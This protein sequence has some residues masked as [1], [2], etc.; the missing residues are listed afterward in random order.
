MLFLRAVSSRAL[1]WLQLPSGGAI[2]TATKPEN[3]SGPRRPRPPRWVTALFL[4]VTLGLLLLPQGREAVSTVEA[5]W[6]D[7]QLTASDRHRIEELA[8]R[9]EKAKDAKG[10]AFAAL[11]N[12]DGEEA[13]QFADRAVAMD[14]KLVW[15]YASRFQRPVETPVSKERI[16]RLLGS[17]PE[18]AFGYLYAAWAEAEP[19]LQAALRD[20][21]LKNDDLESNLAGDAKWVELMGSAFRAP[22]YDTYYDR[23][24]ELS[25]EVWSRERGLG[26]APVAYSLWSHSIPS[27]QEVLAYADLRIR[28]ANEESAANH[29]ERA[30]QILRG[31]RS[32][33]ER[34]T[35][36]SVSE[37]ERMTGLEVER[38][39]TE[40]LQKFYAGKGGEREAREAAAELDRIGVQKTQILHSFPPIYAAAVEPYRRRA[41]LV[42][43]A[44][45]LGIIS[46]LASLFCVLLLE[47]HV[48]LPQ[49]GAGMARRALYLSADY[50]PMLFL[51]SSVA[52]LLSFRP[53]AA[54]L[55]EFRTTDLP[56]IDAR[57]VAG[58][59]FVLGTVD[60]MGALHDAYVR[61]LVLTVVLA[62][63][64]VV[65]LV[66]GIRRNKRAA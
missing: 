18:N 29:P 37:I 17:D 27:I 52:L 54:F 32:F 55:A 11:S 56:S 10:I 25:R 65:V 33:G 34:M 3:S 13:V 24:R 43:Y 40:E 26:I 31:V 8:V 39:G 57:I 4:L 49:P 36:G 59:L 62:V 15:I 61:W 28:G 20:R 47:L 45:L 23:H 64:A 50:G 58:R 41:A 35:A 51:V 12:P 16:D 9:A 2:R 42:Q 5:S 30:E 48:G 19:R 14:P 60:P 53:F 21:C 22:R 46:G 6:R 66:Q 1:D 63:V 7:F 38:R 44:A